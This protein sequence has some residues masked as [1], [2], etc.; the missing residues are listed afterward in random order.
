MKEKTMPF[1]ITAPFA[2]ALGVLS[3]I[4]SVRVSSKR[5]ATKISLGDGGNPAL[6]E[7][8]RQHANLMETAPMAL[9]LLGLAEAQGVPPSWLYASATILLLARL[10]HPF[11][12]GS[13]QPANPLRVIGSVGTTISMLIASIGILRL[14]WGI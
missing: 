6:L 3:I 13:N 10:I 4:L 8:I 9:I 5:G 2:I 11:G 7:R 14:I 1:P 12:I